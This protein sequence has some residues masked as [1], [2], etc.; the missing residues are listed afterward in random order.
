MKIVLLIIGVLSFVFGNAQNKLTNKDV[1]K[2]Y[3]FMQGSF[4]SSQQAAADTNFFNISLQMTK[5]KIANSKGLYLYVE[6]AMATQLNKPYRQRI[7]HVYL[8]DDSTIVS[9]VYELKNPSQY[10][11]GCTN[12]ALIKNIRT[13]SLIDRAGCG[14]YL[15]KTS[16]GLLKGSTP[17]KECLSSLRGAT[18]ATS[19]VTFYAN[20][21]VSW[22]RGWDKNDKQVWGAVLGG[23][24]FVKIK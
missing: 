22:D 17:N 7:Y 4:S 3:A 11:G 1:K 19:E 6:Q 10:I 15:R 5:V 20:K 16:D 24:E 14:I 9:K 21:L 8:Q 2:L 23:Y 12:K 18:Y 13:D